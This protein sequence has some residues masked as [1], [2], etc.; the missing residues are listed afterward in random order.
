MENHT[1]RPES[2]RISVAQG[3]CLRQSYRG[4]S[5][6]NNRRSLESCQ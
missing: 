4:E 2:R 6:S 3:K 1:A 5:K